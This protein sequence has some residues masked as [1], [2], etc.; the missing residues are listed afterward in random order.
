MFA[1]WFSRFFPVDERFIIHRYHSTRWAVLVGVILMAAWVNYEY[2]VN[3]TLRLDF[4]VIMLA[5]AFTKVAVMLYLRL[6][7]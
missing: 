3:Q 7:H 6:T 5:M 2:F 1:N 4:L